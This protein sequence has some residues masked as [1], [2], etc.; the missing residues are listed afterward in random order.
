MFLCAWQVTI[1]RS[2]E[3]GG[4]SDSVQPSREA[5]SNLRARRRAAWGRAGGG[6]PLSTDALPQ[7]TCIIEFTTGA[8]RRPRL[9]GQRDKREGGTKP[10]AI[11]TTY[12]PF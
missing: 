10:K 6:N 3:N 9:P 4:T 12:W 2:Q 11:A 5:A 7:D 8:A 1:F